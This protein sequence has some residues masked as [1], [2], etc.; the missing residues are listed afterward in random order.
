[1]TKRKKTLAIDF[2]GTLCRYQPFKDGDIHEEPMEGAVEVIIK[3]HDAGWK[4]ILWTVRV[5]PDW[6]DHKKQL[7]NIK[8]WLANQGIL[9]KF[10][11]ITATKPIATAYIDDHAIRF[12]NWQ[13]IKN[14]FL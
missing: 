9:E 8:W 1:M 4:L 13:D 11:E 12:T 5:R 6:P 3:L 10:E 2:D 14:Y 7:A